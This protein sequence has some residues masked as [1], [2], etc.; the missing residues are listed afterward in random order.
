M[1]RLKEKLFGQFKDVVQ[2]EDNTN[3]TL[4]YKFQRNDTALKNGSVLTVHPSQMAI[5]VN[6]GKVG[7]VFEPGS[8]TLDTDNK[9]FI[10]D[11]KSWD[12]LF[13]SPWVFECYFFSSKLFSGFWGSTNKEGIYMHCQEL[14]D[15]YFRANG[16]YSFK[17]VDPQKLFTSLSG[18]E[19]F[20][21]LDEF[22]SQLKFKERI[23][24]KVEEL[25]ANATVTARRLQSQRSEFGKQ[26]HEFVAP[27]FAKYGI[28]LDS[29][30]F[31]SISFS[32]EIA[33]TMK[34]MTS[35]NLKL[36]Q[37]MKELK[38][39]GG[40]SAQE[41]N[42]INTLKQ[43]DAMVN[44]S[45][46]EGDIGGMM[47]MGVGYTMMNQMGQQFNQQQQMHQQQMQQQPNMQQGA[48][49]PPPPPVP[50][51]SAYFVAVNGAQT[52]PFTLPV[53]QQMIQQGTF[54]KDSLV[55]KQGMAAWTASAQ[56][57]EISGLFGA[58]PPPLPPM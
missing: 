41:A 49:A 36:Q 18:S 8:Y 17:I 44:F 50:Q 42:T 56:V 13:N 23:S 47:G 2:W 15:I 58:V 25:F 28:E 45:N 10:T 20:Y 35:E 43:G 19:D 6:K 3:D 4:V 1:G 48:G 51:A 33:K 37:E 31:A 22:E 34:E 55:W 57:Q 40:L 52:G 46:N 54:N 26:L 9:M 21:T 27:E 12:F 30:S 7:S 38:A 5:F 16:T 14:G 11:L 39:K 32:E 53:L 29:V 24:G